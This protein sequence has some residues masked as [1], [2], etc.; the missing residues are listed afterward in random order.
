MDNQEIIDRILSGEDLEPPKQFL[1]CF[2]GGRELW[3]DGIE[4]DDEGKPRIGFISVRPHKMVCIDILKAIL[5][6]DFAPVFNQVSDSTTDLEKERMF[7]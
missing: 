4:Y 6:Y 1:A 5:I 7:S 2:E 3:L